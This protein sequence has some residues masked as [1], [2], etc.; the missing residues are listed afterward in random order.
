VILSDRNAAQAHPQ[1]GNGLRTGRLFTDLSA[2]ECAPSS[3]TYCDSKVNTLD[4][5]YAW[6]TGPNSYSQ[7]AAVKDAQGK[8]VTLDAPLQ[9]TFDVPS[10]ASHYGEY[11]GKSIVL[12]YGGYGQLWGIPGH[13]VSHLTN[14]LVSC[15]QDESRYVPEFVIP[16]DE[17][18]GVVREGNNTYLVKWLDREIRFAKKNVSECSALTLPANTALPTAANVKNPLAPQSDIYNGTRPVVTDAPRVVHGEVKY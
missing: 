7:F 16:Y 17:A 12:Q 15:D 13:C 10:D 6:E 3:G 1:Y 11:A 2:A 9:V 4:V 18:S 5:Y 14:E 8:F